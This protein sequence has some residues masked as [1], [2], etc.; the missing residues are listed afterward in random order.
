[1][2]SKYDNKNNKML[3]Q[4]YIDRKAYI[5]KV[6]RE[7]VPFKITSKTPVRSHDISKI[8]KVNQRW[9]TKSPTVAGEAMNKSQEKLSALENFTEI[10]KRRYEHTDTNVT[11]DFCDDPRRA[12]KLLMNRSYSALTIPKRAADFKNEVEWRLSLRP[13]LS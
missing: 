6:K 12:R 1:M 4:A 9:W 3:I 7:S 2:N 11:G 8:P 5:D 13:N 10:T